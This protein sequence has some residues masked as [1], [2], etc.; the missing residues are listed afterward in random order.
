MN[1]Y[2]NLFL[3]NNNLKYEV[4]SS[5]GIIPTVENKNDRILE[6]ESRTVDNVRLNIVMFNLAYPKAIEDVVNTPNDIMEQHYD[7]S[8]ILEIYDD[9]EKKLLYIL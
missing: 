3:S 8:L 9:K 2:L 6:R 4:E 1:F 7:T 5:N